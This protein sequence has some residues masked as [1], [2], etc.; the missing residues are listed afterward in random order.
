MNPTWVVHRFGAAQPPE[1]IPNKT[2]TYD[3]HTNWRD[4]MPMIVSTEKLAAMLHQV[5]PPAD[6]LA[7]AHNTRKPEEDE[8]SLPGRHQFFHDVL[9][10]RYAPPDHVDAVILDW[11]E[12]P[13]LPDW[14]ESE[15]LDN[16][17]DFFAQWGIELGLGLFLSSLPLAYA[18]KK[19]VQVLALTAR[20]E[21]DTKR[22]IVETAQF[23]LDVTKK[24]A[25]QPGEEGYV[26]ARQIRLMH[27]G[28][29]DMIRHDPRVP[30][31]DDT[32]VWP[33]W[34]NDWGEPINQQHLLGT[35]LSFSS[36]LLMVL[37]KFDATYDARGAEDYCLLWN[38]VGWLLGID[39]SILPMD[40]AEMDRL[41]AEI[42]HLNEAECEAGKLMMAAL[43][44][45]VHSLVKVPGFV[46]GYPATLARFLISDETAD[47]LGV[48]PSDWTRVFIHLGQR[49]NRKLSVHAA[50]KRMTR[51]LLR[52]YSRGVLKGFVLVERGDDRPKFSIP[53]SLGAL[54]KPS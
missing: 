50:R 32:T 16:G 1:D 6:A 42:R 22:R 13:E 28:V 40:R 12:G 7:E 26:A 31:T 39:E 17:A 29:R 46:R 33:R 51:S 21:T 19:G 11:A 14:A 27:A 9:A 38:V 48:P 44:E 23:V 15:R 8:A 52:F 20:L 53:T 45:L 41:T 24:G 18:S 43:L 10:S 47:L 34:E 30:L 2:E 54:T 25:L 35:M 3:E 5:D 36:S 37:D 49:T 4:V